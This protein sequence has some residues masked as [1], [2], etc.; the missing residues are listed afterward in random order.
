[1]GPLLRPTWK[2]STP[3]SDH[4]R[5]NP[6]PLLTSY[7]DGVVRFELSP[8]ASLVALSPKLCD[9]DVSTDND[10]PLFSI[11]RHAGLFLRRNGRAAPC[12][13]FLSFEWNQT[14]YIRPIGRR[15]RLH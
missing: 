15:M 10:A 12:E 1:M 3:C 6:Q 5:I 11:G 9:S 2:N 4:L 14:F 13:G 8:Q 7:A